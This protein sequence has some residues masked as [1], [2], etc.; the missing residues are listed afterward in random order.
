MRGEQ[1]F[2]LTAGQSRGQGVLTSLVIWESRPRIRS[3]IDEGTD[4]AVMVHKGIQG[5]CRLH[6]TDEINMV[7]P[8]PAFKP[9]SEN[10]MAVLGSRMA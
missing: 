4:L 10:N 2:C 6:E 8:A 9:L 7:M 3:S 1:R 5:D